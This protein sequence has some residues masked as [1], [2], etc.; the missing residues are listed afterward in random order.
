MDYEVKNKAETETVKTDEEKRKVRFEEYC[1]H[2]RCLRT[3][4]NKGGNK[5]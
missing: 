4:K 3:G 2:F 1:T 5:A